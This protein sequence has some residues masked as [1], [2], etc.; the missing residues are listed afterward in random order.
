VQYTN[1]KIER[2][3]WTIMAKRKYEKHFFPNQLIKSDDVKH[4]IVM[5]GSKTGFDGLMKNYWLRWSCITKPRS[6]GNDPHP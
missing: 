2:E 3:E 1:K 4:R 6:M 5:Q